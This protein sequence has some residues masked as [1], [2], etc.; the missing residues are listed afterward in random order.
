M[1]K[2]LASKGLGCNRL[3]PVQQRSVILSHA[4]VIPPDVNTRRID[5]A[6]PPETLC[7][8]MRT[9]FVQVEAS[10]TQSIK[11]SWEKVIFIIIEMKNLCKGG[12]G[13]LICC[14]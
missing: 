7:C 11:T 12:T 8:S 3:K 1:K 10:M 4:M 6:P 9:S 13:D 14:R 5:R 2:P